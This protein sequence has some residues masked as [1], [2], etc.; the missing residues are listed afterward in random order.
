MSH[1]PDLSQLIAAVVA[2]SAVDDPVERLA[3][4]GRVRDEL[5]ELTEA[6]LDHFVEQARGAG[7]SW[8]QIG[9]ALGFSKQ[10]AQQRH[11]STRS[12]ARRL[13][14]WLPELPRS[15]RGAFFGRFTDRA[16]A[17]VVLAQDEARRFDH[18]YLGTE[19]ILLGLLREE[20]GVAAKALTSMGVSL[21][22]TRERVREL[23]GEGTEPAGGR[24]PFTP[25]AKKALELSLREA[26]ALGHDYVGTEHILLGLVREGDGVAARMLEGMGIDHDRSRE[27]VLRVLADGA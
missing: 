18:N 2:E 24:V 8:S 3:T 9:G 11:A 12:V 23:I 17:V 10:A 25:R 14:S 19:H 1:L 26:R 6:M 15:R 22:R 13:L 16:R 21:G 4:A 5:H 20:Q 27:A 7:C